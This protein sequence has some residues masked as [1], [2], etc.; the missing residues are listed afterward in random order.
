MAPR[1][2]PALVVYVVG[3]AVTRMTFGAHFPL[4]VIVGTIIG[5]E[6]GLFTVAV[7]RAA[8]LVPRARERAALAPGAAQP[9]PATA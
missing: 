5:W 6:V 4:D 3:V 7:M 1:L 8:W 2:R 9:A